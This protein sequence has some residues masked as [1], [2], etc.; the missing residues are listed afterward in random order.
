[1]PKPKS[2]V[3]TCEIEGCDRPKK[4]RGLCAKHYLSDYLKKNPGKNV[5]GPTRGHPLYSIWFERKQRGSLCE[6][7]AADV[8]VFAE[9]V[10]ERPSPTHLLRRLRAGE[11]Y[12]PDNFEWMAAL[13]RQ[14]GESREAFNSRKW[15]SRRERLPTFE[16][17]R[18][19][20]RKYG[21]TPEAFAAMVEAQDGKCAICR[22]PE[23]A[24][25]AKTQAPKA[26]AVDHCHDSKKVRGLLC[27][28]CNTTLG[29]VEDSTVLLGEMIAYLAATTTARAPG[30]PGALSLCRMGLADVGGRW[31]QGL[32]SPAAPTEGDRMTDVSY[33]FEYLHAWHTDPHLGEGRHDHRWKVIAYFPIEPWRDGR[34]LKTSLR[35]I[36]DVW[37][38]RD[39]PPELW[40]AEQLARAILQAH[41][42]ADCCGVQIDRREGF[43]VKVG[44]CG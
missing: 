22:Q 31:H 8:L 19:L 32:R 44:V 28:R 23:T 24:L 29:K 34:S 33:V 41:G 13:K 1:M 10:G 14:P 26:L 4:S 42:N 17:Q 7:W 30:K 9:A 20:M 16:P 2:Q 35:Q 18:W 6:E 43:G 38:G 27:W 40:S 37:E 21:L 5:S 11:P 25:D 36:L 15:K 12:G 3:G 39:L